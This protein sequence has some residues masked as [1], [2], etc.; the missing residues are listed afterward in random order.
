MRSIPA[1]LTCVLLFSSASPSAARQPASAPP[2]D[3]LAPSPTAAEASPV[4]SPPGGHALTRED[5]TAWIDGFMPYALGRGDIPG[6][7]VVVVKDGEVLLEKGYGYSDVATLKP[8]DP[9]LTLFR[10]GSVS[11]LFTWTAVMQLVEQKKIDLDADITGYLDYPLP[12]RDGPPITMRNLMTHTPGFDE[13]QRALIVNDVKDLVTLEQALKHWVPPRV[14]AAGSVPAYSNYGAA[15]AGYIVQR[16]S[17]MPFDDYLEKNIFAPLG[18]THATFRQP[19]PAAMEPAMSK[20]YKSGSDEPQPFE[21]IALA[22]AGSMSASGAD[23]ARFMIAHLQKGAYGGNRILEEATAVAMHDTASKVFPALNGMEL[24]FYQ[25][26]LNGHRI[27]AHGG[28]TQWFH[29]DLNLFVDDGVGI[30]LSVNSAGKDGAAH[31]LRQ[32]LLAQFA[33]RYF[34]DK[35][36]APETIDAKTASEHAALLA[37]RYIF[38][39]RSHETFIALLNLVSQVKV[40]PDKDGAIV[41]P[42]LKGLNEQQLKFKE[43]A[44]FVWREVNGESELAAQVD[45]GRVVRAGYGPYPFMLFEPVPWWYSS[46]WLLPLWVAAL[47]ALLLTVLAWPISALVRRRYG[48]PYGL[49]GGDAVAHRRIRL[50]SL[51]TVLT[52]IVLGVTLGMMFS[53]FKWLAPGIEKW[54]SLLRILT[55]LVLVGGTAI[56]L[57]NASVVLR[58]PRRWPAKVWSVILAISFLALLYVGVV[59]KMVGFSGEF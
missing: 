15:L 11:K 43:V 22:P 13:I 19:L 48:V 14:T 31:P 51:A 4:P 59:F 56:A 1:V 28:D 9:E 35:A 55:L 24:G 42:A 58:C 29:S 5:V 6:A 52:M 38:S 46:G 47:V 18:M 21:M 7:V 54:I 17:G 27:I 12:K 53:D 57:W 50:A 20:G 45:G 49:S 10:P 8:V 36:A 26:D 23:M 34:P 3:P 40:G 33:D 32:T 25:S 2:Q 41:V 37:G 30:F 44:P 16:L 39:R